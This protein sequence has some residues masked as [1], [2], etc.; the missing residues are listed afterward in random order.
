[1]FFVLVLPILALILARLGRSEMEQN[2]R[3]VRV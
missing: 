3:A 1:M 2:R